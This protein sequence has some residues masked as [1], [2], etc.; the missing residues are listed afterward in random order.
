[1]EFAEVESHLHR[2]DE[3]ALRL[4]LEE[5]VAFIEGGGL[6]HRF[7]SMFGRSAVTVEDIDTLLDFLREQL[8]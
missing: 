4:Q 6:D 7:K 8:R 5:A 1:M 2:G 3:D